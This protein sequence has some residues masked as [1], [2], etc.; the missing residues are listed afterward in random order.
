[1]ENRGPSHFGFWISDLGFKYTTKSMEQGGK[2][3]LIKLKIVDETNQ[4]CSDEGNEMP[5]ERMPLGAT[6]SFN[7]GH[8]EVRRTHGP[9]PLITPR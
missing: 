1:M 3:G 2:E 8:V 7:L 4:C 9:G 6:T 5:G